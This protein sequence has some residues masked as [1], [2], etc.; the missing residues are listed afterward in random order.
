M[1]S[2]E[3]VGRVLYR[4]ALTIILDKPA[5]MPVH[6]GPRNAQERNAQE[7]NQPGSVP[8]TSLFEAL[9]FGLPRR[10]ELAHRL[11]RDTS[12][13]LVLGRNRAALER[14]GKL[15]QLGTVRK[16]YWAVVAG[17]PQSDAGV[18]DLP[19]GRRD[20]SRG[21]WMKVD[22]QGQA[23]VTN[24]RLLGHAVDPHGVE[25]SALALEPVTGRTHQLRVHCAAMGWPI[26]G[27]AVY[28]DA[29]RLAEPALHLHARSIELPLY[30]KRDPIKAK[31]PIPERM[32]E[33]L[34][35]CGV[36]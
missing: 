1:T 15:F 29:E 6:A 19:L 14:L 28:G 18:I 23:A 11:D 26:L 7:R 24:W 9:R 16:T 10:P 33:A 36:T 3:L 22:P 8:L 30:P 5:G 27:D 12:G 31:A 35:A 25:I 20:K 17:R 34:A 4:D 32:R 13:C 2:E 21:W